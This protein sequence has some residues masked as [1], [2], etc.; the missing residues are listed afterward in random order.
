MIMT[1][2]RERDTFIGEATKIG[3]SMDTIRLLLRYATTLQRLAIA[4]CNGDWPADNGERTT[5]ACPDCESGFVPSSFKAGPTPGINGTKVC[6]DCYA[7]YRVKAILA[8]TNYMPWFQGDP[9][10]A[11]LSLYPVGSP[12]ADI[13]SGRIHGIYV[14]PGVR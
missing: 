14:P 2:Q 10:G 4:Q 8:D 5:I 7:Q 13:D 12:S 3:L 1:Y 6:P 11:V 9:R